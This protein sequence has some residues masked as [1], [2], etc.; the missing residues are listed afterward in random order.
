MQWNIDPFIG[1]KL[2]I[3]HAGNLCLMR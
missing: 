2:R 3:S 1:E